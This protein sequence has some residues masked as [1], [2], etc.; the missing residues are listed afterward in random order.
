MRYIRPLSIEDAVG[1]LAGSAGPAAILAG[2][3]DLLVRMKGGFVEPE[4]IIDIKSIAG[5]RDIRETADGFSIGAA[6]P[7]A[8][9]GENAA[10]KKAWPG[11]VEAAKLIGSK[12]VQGRCT[13]VGNLCNAS[14]AA[15]SVPA[16]VAAGAKAVVV[17]PSGKRTIAV[18]TVPT[19]PGRTSLAKGEIIEAILLGKRAPRSADAYLR[20]IPRTEMDIAVVSAGVNLTLD[21]A[22]VVTAARVAIGAAAPTVLLV[23]EGAEA[24]IGRKLD[25]AA[26]ER[27]AKVCAGTCRPIDDKRGTIEFRRKVAGVLAKRAAQTAYARAG[28][29]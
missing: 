12:Q 23:E 28:G 21:E 13:I 8:V 22:G 27:L 17:G 10:L 3:S 24:L 26:L 19:A 18:E 29:K 2:G 1:Q 20:F 4:L 16:L 14:P 7:C 5:L 9:L 11:V 25:E 6:V 15:D